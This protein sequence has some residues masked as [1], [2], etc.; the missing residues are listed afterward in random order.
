MITLEQAYSIAKK[1]ILPDGAYFVGIYE[2]AHMWSFEYT[3]VND[4]SEPVV[5]IGINVV[6]REDGRVVSVGSGAVPQF[7]ETN[8]FGKEVPAKKLLGVMTPEDYKL[9]VDFKELYRATGDEDE[10]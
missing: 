2:H 5:G 9:L 3:C 4:H 1:S 8:G 6:L 7:F 10:E